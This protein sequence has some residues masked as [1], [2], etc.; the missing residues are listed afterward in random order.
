MLSLAWVHVLVEV[1]AIE[2]RQAMCVFRKMRWYPIHN[3]ADAGLMAAVDKMAELVRFTEAA[4]RRVVVGNLITPGA[5]EWML[6]YRHEFDVSVTHFQNVGQKRVGQLQ[7]AERAI[8][9][10]QLAS[11]RAEVHFVNAERTLRPILCSARFHPSAV[12]PLKAVQII[13]Q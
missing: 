2:L 3:H 8:P 7:I 1:G 13:H 11:P 10:L 12:G 9:L 5:F 6:G 4:G